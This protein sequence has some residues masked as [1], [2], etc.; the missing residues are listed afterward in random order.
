LISQEKSRDVK[1]VRERKRDRV[2]AT[3]ASFIPPEISSEHD[4]INR[5]IE[6][7]QVIATGYGMMGIWFAFNALIPTDNVVLLK[8]GT[9]GKPGSGPEVSSYHKENLIEILLICAITSLISGIIR[10]LSS[11]FLLRSIE[12]VRHPSPL[13]D[14]SL[15]LH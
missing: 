14:L 15:A 6:F 13:T 7:I 2:K 8:D 11:L 1:R 5:S 3:A 4:L 9:I 12:K 10:F